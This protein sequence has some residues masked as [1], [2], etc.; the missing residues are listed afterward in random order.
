MAGADH[1]HHPGYID[2]PTYED[3]LARIAGNTRRDRMQR[4]AAP[5]GKEAHCCKA[6]P[7]AVTAGGGCI[8]TTRDE[9]PRRAITAR[10]RTSS[11]EEAC[12]A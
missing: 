9:L 4:G 5:S 6:L 3:N 11:R 12:T 8:P 7:R 10:E 2:W 1:Q